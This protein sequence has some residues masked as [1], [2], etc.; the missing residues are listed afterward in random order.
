MGTLQRDWICPLTIPWGSAPDRRMPRKYNPSPPTLGG[1]VRHRP[2]SEPLGRLAG[3]LRSWGTGAHVLQRRLHGS[4]LGRSADV[5]DRVRPELCRGR[6]V[7]HG[8]QWPLASVQ[9]PGHSIDAATV[10]AAGTAL[11]EVSALD[12]RFSSC[13]G[14]ASGRNWRGHAA[15]DRLCLCARDAH[16][17]PCAVAADV[18]DLQFCRRRWQRLVP[19]HLDSPPAAECATDAP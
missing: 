3:Y 10:L 8:V 17:Q 13:L 16:V 1:T 9:I 11:A 6:L 14:A 18:R 4:R 15:P 7:A 5:A 2:R 12:S 19:E